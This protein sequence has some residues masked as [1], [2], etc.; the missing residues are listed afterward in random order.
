MKIQDL[1]KLTTLSIMT[2]SMLY[3]TNSN[4]KMKFD[5]I[6][7]TANKIEENVQ[8]VPQ[9]ITVIDKEILQEKNIDTIVRLIEEIP[10]MS[11]SESKIFGIGVNFRGLNSS[12]FT[13]SNPIVIYIDGVPIV[14]KYTYK[15]SL[16]N[17][18][19]VEV[20]RGPQ[21]SLY[22]KDAIGGVVNIVTDDSPK[23]LS[24]YINVEYGSNNLKKT[25][26][27]INAPIIKNRL[28]A[29]VNGEIKQDDG[30]ITNT[31][32]NDDKAEK[33]ESS[34]FSGYLNY[35]YSDNLSI[36]LGLNKSDIEDY[37]LKGGPVDETLTIN[38]LNRDNAKTNSFDMPTFEKKDDK[39]NSL[40]IRYGTD[41]FN[42]GWVSTKRDTKT[43]A[44]HDADHRDSIP[45]L[46]YTNFSVKETDTVTHELR[47]SSKKGAIKWVAGLYMDDEKVEQGPYGMGGA[48]LYI[49][50]DSISD[51]KT[52]AI[53]GQAMIPLGNKYELTLGGRYQKI[54]K[55]M[56][57]DYTYTFGGMSMSGYPIELKA[58]K[59]WNK[60]IPKVA[61]SYT[62]NKNFTPF[63]SISQGYMPGGFNHSASS[64]NPADATFEP[65]QSTNYEI[66]I[67]GMGEDFTYAASIF[68]MNIK[69]I[70]IYRSETFNGGFNWVTDNA[71]K[72]HS[73]GIEFEGRYFITDTLDLSGSIGLI[74][75]RYDDY[76]FGIKKFDG[77]DIENIPSH[78]INLTLTYK[79]INGIYGL[80]NIKNEGSTNFYNNTNQRFI[81]SNGNTVLNA[82]IG[83]KFS[84]W[85]IYGYVNNIT[86]EDH[87]IS[88]TSRPGLT[89]AEFNDPRFIGVGIRYSF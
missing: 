12:V 81:K 41:N 31:Y 65:Q 58:K 49:S 22:G 5:T 69:D 74:K 16:T 87:V 37:F 14:D 70:H 66:G 88:H 89:L 17:A 2:S 64:S 40:A 33:S 20:L 44:I 75:A 35:L 73:M 21:G 77:E 3:G 18:K 47:A 27:N 23:S 4:E 48:G 19:R 71:N 79:G 62:N 13:N 28:F 50:I 25:S 82:K 26:F 76:D 53:F 43:D 68:Y 11:V 10:N 36:K 32:H 9:S 8:K 72:A 63:I 15:V 39:Y 80:F 45:M 85:D 24:G 51:S 83:Y 34:S 7:V 59:D 55:E 30:W 29:G 56:D 52:K 6:T 84:N 46:G 67:K 42:I 60:L 78:T 54:E 1:I 86:D 38:Q 57:L 61:L